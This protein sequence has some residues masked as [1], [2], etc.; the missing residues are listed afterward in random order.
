[1]RHKR[2][3]RRLNRTME[4]GWAL[5]RNMAQ[6]LFEHGEINTTLPKA[7]NLRPFA[8]RLITLAVKSRKF[9]RA[10]DTAAALGARRSIDKL[11]GDRVV[12]P[13]AHQPTYDAMSDAARKRTVRMSSGRRH[14]TGEPKGRLAFTA[15]SITRRLI[16][17]VA[18]RFMDRP[19]GYTRIIRL[20]DWRI[21]DASRLA[22]LQLVGDEQ[23]PG[24]IS[25][26][27]KTARRRRSDAR[28]AFA[29]KTAKGRS[30]KAR[31]AAPDAAPAA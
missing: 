17:V 18:P 3:F 19:G 21:G 28:Y 27:G 30:A 9:Q 23:S 11:L 16:D 10:G 14:R 26:P 13:E 24:A 6:S 8:E 12:I 25:K 31:G 15:D 20:S 22:V 5:R 4:H 29:V 1:M 7:K 2:H